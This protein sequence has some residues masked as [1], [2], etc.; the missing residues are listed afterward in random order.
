MKRLKIVGCQQNTDEDIPMQDE[1]AAAQAIARECIGF[2]LQL[3]GRVVTALY[4]DALRPHGL[5][6]SQ[7][8]VLAAVGRLGRRRPSDLVWVLHL[9]KSTVSRDVQELL[10][11]L[12]RLLDR[13]WLEQTLGDDGRTHYLRLTEAGH[14]LLEKVTPAWR[15]AQSQVAALLGDQ[16][17]AAITRAVEGLRAETAKDGAGPGLLGPGGTR[18]VHPGDDHQH[19]EKAKGWISR[20]GQSHTPLPEQPSRAEE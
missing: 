20:G 13:G 12:E 3:L 6:V 4:H 9:D 17:V 14:A 1:S 11:D 16:T 19:G 2:R 10:S 18:G 7:L 15:E 8:T 5:R